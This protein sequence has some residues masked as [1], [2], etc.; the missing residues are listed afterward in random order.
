MFASFYPLKDLDFWFIEVVIVI[1][2]YSKIFLVQIY[3]HQKFAIIFNLIPSFLKIACIILT[4]CSKERERETTLYLNLNYIW[5][6]IFVGPLINFSFTAI[7]SFI[8]C[9]LKSFLELKYTSISQLLMFY[10][11]SG[12]IISFLITI[13]STYIPCTQTI[14]DDSFSHKICQLKYDNEIYFEHFIKYFKTFFEDETSVKIIRSL[15]II[16]DS[17]TF[18]I[19]KYLLLLS[20]KYTDPVH[21]Y[22]YIPFYYIFQ[23]IML[24]VNNKIETN[25]AFEDISNFRVT[26]YFLDISGDIFCMVHTI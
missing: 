3:K 1:F 20:I 25:E 23:K 4:I 12:M 11:S 6:I 16:L 7:D 17:L 10:G 9:S 24:V 22:F 18:F 5:W 26:N 14:E 21:I 19:Y 15:I 13:I 2:I 8:N